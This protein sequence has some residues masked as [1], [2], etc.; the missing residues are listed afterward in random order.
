MNTWRYCTRALAS[1]VLAVCM[2]VPAFAQETTSGIRG[3]VIDANG[4]PVA[5]AEVVIRD[6]RTGIRRQLA[7]NSSGVFLAARLPVGGPY[8]ITINDTKTV[9]IPFIE[10]G[11]TY[12]LTVNL[13][14]QEA[15]EEIV[16][17][18]QQASIITTAPGP[19]SNFTFEDI[20]QA[21]AINRE[22]ADVF[23]I[24]PR[25]NIDASGGRGIGVNCAGKNPRFN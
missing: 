22:L 15:I 16:T 13:Q 18:G 3:K 4:E 24:D 9:E 14:Q 8:E 2:A 21:V 12:K 6:D 20:N 25:I 10:L 19:Q 7:T 5:N 17:I 11:D 23:A 1:L